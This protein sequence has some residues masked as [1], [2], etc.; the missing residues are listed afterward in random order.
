M[1]FKQKLKN[2]TRKNNSLLCIGLDTDLEKIPKNLLKED[3]P[4]FN[5]N[6]AIIDFTYDLVCAYKPNIAFYEAYGLEG[7]LSLKK[8]IEYLQTKYSE[9]PIIFDAKRGDIGNTAK[10]YAKAVF[11][12]WGA[13]AVTV[14]PYLGF[15]SIKPFLKYK[16]KGIIILCRT[17]NE[18]AKDFQDT[19]VPIEV[20]LRGGSDTTPREKLQPIYLLVAKKVVEWD[21]KYKNCSLVVGAT[22]PEQL[23]EVRRIALEMFFLI[24]GIGTQGGDLK[25]TL[26][27]GLTKQKS[28]L[29][30]NVG[31]SILCASG[32]EDF[33]K[34]ARKKATE[35][36][37]QINKY[38]YG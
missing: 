30:I 20:H 26:E 23:K 21:K 11:E 1:S 13:D 27:Y 24:P 29:I 35:F 19:K 37:D 12:Y 28:G 7:L 15:D 4:I 36:R 8:T 16:D 17:S 10:M 31:R 33:V 32:K 9:I 3:D 5:F 2:I 34:S 18:G 38:R 14:N 25:K 6:K 22:W